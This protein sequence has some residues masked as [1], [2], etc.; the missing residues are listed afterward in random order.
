M[1]HSLL[2]TLPRSIAFTDLR[3]KKRILLWLCKVPKDSAHICAFNFILFYA[4]F[5][6]LFSNT[7]LLSFPP[8]CHNPSCLWI[9]AHAVYPAFLSLLNL[10]LSFRSQLRIFPPWRRPASSHDT[11][12]QLIWNNYHTLWL[13]N[14]KTHHQNYLL[15]SQLLK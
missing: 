15:P 9:F 3:T 4:A 13:Y 5:C 7:G 1:Q 11:H 2:K 12:V 6:A 14:N 10:H 8:T